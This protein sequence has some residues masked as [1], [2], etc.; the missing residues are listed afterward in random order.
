MPIYDSDLKVLGMN[1]E[2]LVQA[3]DGLEK[4][5]EDIQ[6]MFAAMR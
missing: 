4:S 2:A 5:R 3:E 6:L 1:A